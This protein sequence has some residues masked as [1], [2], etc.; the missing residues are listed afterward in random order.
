MWSGYWDLNFALLVNWLSQWDQS[1]CWCSSIFINSLCLSVAVISWGC[2]V[3]GMNRWLYGQTVYLQASE[4]RNMAKKAGIRWYSQR[5]YDLFLSVR[6]LWC[7]SFAGLYVWRGR[8]QTYSFSNV[9]EN[10][11][12]FCH[13]SA[14]QVVD[15]CDVLQIFFLL[16][17]TYILQGNQIA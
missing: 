14:L 3:R 9:L 6:P 15:C 1:V 5:F 17:I 2:G 7:V 12:L 8:F 16:S 13:I 10:Q 11:K 4:G